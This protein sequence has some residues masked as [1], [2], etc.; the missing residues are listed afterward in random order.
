MLLLGDE[1]LDKIFIKDFEVFAK[2][3]VFGEEKKLGQKFIIS[4][5]LELDLRKAAVTG[6]LNET[7][8]YGELCH[9]IEREFTKEK[10]DLIETAA[11]KIAEFILLQYN[12]VKTVKVMLKKPW[13]P[14]GKH[15][16]Y[17]AVEIKRAWHIVYVG[18]GSNMGNKEKNL[19]DAIK[20][21]DDDCRNKVS[22]ISKFYSTKPVGYLN[23]DDFLNCAIEVKTMLAPVEFMTT[24]LEFEKALKRE[25]IIHWGPR[26]IDLDILM[27]D[28][29]VT[30]DE[31]CIIPH[32]RMSERLFVIEPLCDIAPHLVHPLLNRRMTDI[33]NELDI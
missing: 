26:T 30:Y 10:Y 1:E 14:I 5:E 23:Q 22:K 32:P 8:N 28:D 17:V 21:I 16:E 18:M 6:N 3:G 33:K 2:H 7:V 31:H 19:K 4:V 25:R 11:E 15:V 13:A 24:L 12:K 9:E 27:Y 29:L 20:L